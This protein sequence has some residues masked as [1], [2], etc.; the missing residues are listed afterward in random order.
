MIENRGDFRLVFLKAN[1]NAPAANGIG[2]LLRLLPSAKAARVLAI[3]VCGPG[4]VSVPNLD[5]VA[6][7]VVNLRPLYL[8]VRGRPCGRS[9]LAQL[10]PKCLPTR[11][12]SSTEEVG[13]KAV[14]EMV[15]SGQDV[16]PGL[17][18]TCLRMATIVR[19]RKRYAEEIFTKDNPTRQGKSSSFVSGQLPS[20]TV[21][22]GVYCNQSLCARNAPQKS[23]RPGRRAARSGRNG[24]AKEQ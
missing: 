3:V 17:V 18:H 24:S 8:A 20:P 5:A 23:R 9:A 16:P 12:S 11:N 2:E 19:R 22:A 14:E 13:K 7:P 15:E 1:L 6:V 4:I 10:L 21:L